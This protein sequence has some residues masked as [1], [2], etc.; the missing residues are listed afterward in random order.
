MVKKARKRRAY[1][2][3]RTAKWQYRDRAR[4]LKALGYASYR[5]YL[6]SDTWRLIRAKV[7]ART[8]ICEVCSKN[9]ATQVHHSVYNQAVLKGDDLLPLFAV[10][11]GCH[12]KA[13][14][15]NRDKKKISPWQATQKMRQTARRKGV[16]TMHRIQRYKSLARIE[17]AKIKEFEREEGRR[18][19]EKSLADLKA[20]QA[21]WVHPNKR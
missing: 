2:E 10:C 4:N 1:G 21:A 17:S 7:L 14:F 11:G 9:F 12:F 5:D 19:A 6:H 16:R 8:P 3:R 18:N 15:R 20:R 13:E